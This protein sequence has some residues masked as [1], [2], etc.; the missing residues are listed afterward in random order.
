LDDP[1]LLDTIFAPDSIKNKQNTEAVETEKGALV[2]ARVIEYRPAKLHALSEVSSSIREKLVAENAAKLAEKQGQTLLARLG[3]GEEP[4]L[5]WS[6]FQMV[7]RQ[8]PG[9]FNAQSLPIIFR[10]STSKL[11]AYT[12]VIMPDGHYRLVRI[13]RVSEPSATDPNMV[14]ALE[15]GLRQ[16]FARADSEAYLALAKSQNKVEIKP[17]ALETKE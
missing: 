8:Q 15:D 17:S 4:A 13:S 1:K 16:T 10:V 9:P 6:S 3:K 2:S 12:G 7:S 14:T 5:A 11:P